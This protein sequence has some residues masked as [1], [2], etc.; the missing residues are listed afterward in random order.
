MPHPPKRPNTIFR[1]RPVKTDHIYRRIKS[2]GLHGLHETV[3]ILPIPMN[4][5]RPIRHLPT[6]PPVKTRHLMPD[7]HQ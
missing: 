4:H 6:L 3:Y 1:I 2:L 5:P 7:I